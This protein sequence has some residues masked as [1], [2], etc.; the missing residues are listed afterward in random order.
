MPLSRSLGTLLALVPLLGT[1]GCNDAIT[2]PP[3]SVWET[4]FSSTEPRAAFNGQAGVVS[5]LGA[6]TVSIV[7]ERGEAGAE[8]GWHL[9][10]GTCTQLVASIGAPERYPPLVLNEAG[11]AERFATIGQMLDPA[12]QYAV[13]V[14]TDGG[15]RRLAC[16]DLQRI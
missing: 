14:H 8:F 11:S 6:T 15:V 10:R 13:V 16:G 4:E 1:A 5:Q 12:G 7:V 3:A 2:Q 9:I